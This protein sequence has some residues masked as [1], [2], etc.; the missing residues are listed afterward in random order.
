MVIIIFEQQKKKT[1]IGKKNFVNFRYSKTVINERLN[2][3]KR[4]MSLHVND[5][6]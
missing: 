4:K 6:S 3:N 5:H 2:N 1:E